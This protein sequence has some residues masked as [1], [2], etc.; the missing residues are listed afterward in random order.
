MVVTFYLVLI[1]G[2][3]WTFWGN[4][5]S[6]WTV[7]Y[8]NF[9]SY[10][11]KQQHLDLNIHLPLFL[12]ITI[13]VKVRKALSQFLKFVQSLEWKIQSDI[14]NSAQNGCY[15][16]QAVLKNINYGENKQKRLSAKVNK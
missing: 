16:K 5:L 7:H 14:D 2:R 10:H 6:L 4:S 13:C 9:S 8:D 1:Y 11:T 12:D 15:N 3:T